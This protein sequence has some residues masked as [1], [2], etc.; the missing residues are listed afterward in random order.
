MRNTLSSKTATGTARGSKAEGVK[1]STVPQRA[2]AVAVP[3]SRRAAGAASGELVAKEYCSTKEAAQLL[4][5]SLGTVQQ[6]VEA[7]VLEGWKTAGGH[8]RIRVTSVER[9]LVR[10]VTGPASSGRRAHDKLVVIVA[11][12]AT[13]SREFYEKVFDDTRLAVETRVLGN[14][15]DVLLE[16]GRNPPDLLIIDLDMDVLDGFE[17]VRRIRSSRVAGD[18]DI[19]AV[20]PIA[21]ELIEKKGGLPPDVTVYF[22]PAPMAEL[23]G[24]LQALVARRSRLLTC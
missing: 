17:M 19:V 15:F 8:R 21:A 4:G 1:K 22:E 9:F 7:G 18:M 12:E 13:A 24:Y 14:G 16:V 20:S 10:S 11:A 3:A 6:M 2:T 5:L 23:R